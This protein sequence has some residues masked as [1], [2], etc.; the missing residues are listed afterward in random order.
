MAAPMLTPDTPATRQAFNRL[1]RETMKLRLLAD[2]R[3][4]LMVC[5]LEGWSKLEY[6][7][8]LLALAQELRKGGGGMREDMQAICDSL[9][10]TLQ[11]TSLFCDLLDLKY[12]IED[13]GKQRVMAIFPGGYV[14]VNVTGDSG[15]AMAFDILKQLPRK[16]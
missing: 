3:T 5:E 6:L 15:W 12:I 10:C 2:I 16:I 13:N 8:E 9:C 7:D 11:Q 4:D 1:A 14:Y